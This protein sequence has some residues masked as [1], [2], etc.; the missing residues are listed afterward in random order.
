MECSL[1]EL[2]IYFYYYYFI[3][4]YS[5]NF[6]SKGSNGGIL[7]MNICW[8]ISSSFFFSSSVKAQVALVLSLWNFSESETW[9]KIAFFHWPMADS[10][11]SNKP[12]LNRPAFLSTSSISRLTLLWIYSIH[13]LVIT[14]FKVKIFQIP[15]IFTKRS[16][17]C[18]CLY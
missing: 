1:F 7:K 15:S 16:L 8:S 2:G 9:M 18:C 4:R 11:R 6:P 13:S 5:E 3:F 17:F 12:I 14:K 10:S